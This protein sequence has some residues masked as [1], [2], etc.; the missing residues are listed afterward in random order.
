MRS[1]RI[2]TG[3]LV[4]RGAHMEAIDELRG[5]AIIL[6]IL[7]HSG[8]VLGWPNYLH[9]E[10]GVDIFLLVS[11]FT[12]AVSSSDLSL[13]TFVSRRLLRI[14]PAYWL[15]LA[16]ILWTHRILFGSHYSFDDIAEH[17]I[18]I[19]GFS[20]LAYFSDI[21]DSFW[22][23]SMILAAYVVFALVRRRLDDLSLLVGLCGLLTNA[24][25]VGYQHFGHT[26][27]LISLA[28]RI[29]SFFFGLIA[30]RLLSAGTAELRVNLCLTLG[31]A[32][33]YYMTFFRNMACTYTLPAIGLALAWLAL[34]RGLGRFSL[35]R[36]VLRP[37]ALLG[38]VSYEVYLFHQPLIRD[39]AGAFLA[40]AMNLPNP[41]Q[42]QLGLAI[43]GGLAV[44]LM[45]S[46]LVHRLVGRFFRRWARNEPTPAP[47]GPR[48]GP[49]LPLSLC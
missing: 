38:V 33:T 26:G 43:L 18:G 35:G 47:P 37:V 46:V 17:A 11:G 10:V 7:Y 40:R 48:H 41:T 34:R 44:T 6:V 14:Y 22:F 9:G 39:Y 31:L 36:W 27:G 20:R 42:T 30:G 8:G 45:I 15:A 21:N 23:I 3:T 24:A 13:G 2:N 16:T 49:A 5:L 28:A 25:V 4:P 1:F 32:S 19:H 29:P 12:L